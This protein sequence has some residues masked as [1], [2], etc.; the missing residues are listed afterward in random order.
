MSTPITLH[1]AR[2]LLLCGLGLACLGACE[3]KPPGAKP[4][5][6]E[7][8][9]ASFEN[10]S[11][12]PVATTPEPGPAESAGEATSATSQG[13]FEAQAADPPRRVIVYYFHRTLRCPA[14]LSIEEQSR[15]AV[16]RFY[17]D[18]LS[19]GLLEWR[20]VNVEEAGNE[21]FEKDFSL[22]RQ[23]LILAEMVGDEVTRWRL[24]PK[25]W[26]L[27]E[28]PE[29]FRDYVVSEVAIFLAGG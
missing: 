12:R 6:A 25:V 7:A 29:A 4:N 2:L 1:R 20:S 21:H 3:K 14:C 13:A 19:S 8:M 9:T 5:A 23:S 11:T 27:L 16:E 28:D 18:E 24:L 22:E 15:Q 26:E 17:A 10:S